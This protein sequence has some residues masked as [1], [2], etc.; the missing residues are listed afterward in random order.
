MGVAHHSSYVAW[1]EETR[2][3]FLR[4]LVGGTPPA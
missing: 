3:E 1:F 2:V 4:A